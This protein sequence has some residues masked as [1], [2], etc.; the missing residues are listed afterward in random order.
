MMTWP[1][2]L[3]LRK[4]A[5]QRRGRARRGHVI[6]VVFAPS[7]GVTLGATLIA[8]TAAR[9]E[10]LTDAVAPS[11]RR[12]HRLR[13]ALVTLDEDV[14]AFAPTVDLDDGVLRP[15]E[16]HHGHGPVAALAAGN[17]RVARHR[18]R[19]EERRVG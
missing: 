3:K 14:S 18:R 2:G 5:P 15:M 7:D 19:S 11:R 17:A 12:R 4:E 9:L 16:T 6:T 1:S 8:H 13:R 10:V